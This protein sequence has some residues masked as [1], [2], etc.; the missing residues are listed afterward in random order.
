MV[1]PLTLQEGQEVLLQNIKTKLWTIKGV[2]VEVRSFG[3][4]ALVQTETG[5]FLRN[6]RFMRCLPGAREGGQE[7][8]NQEGEEDESHREEEEDDSVYLGAVFKSSMKEESSLYDLTQQRGQG[9]HTVSFR[10]SCRHK[11]FKDASGSE[12]CKGTV[13]TAGVG[14]AVCCCLQP[15]LLH[16]LCVL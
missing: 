13:V 8:D 14:S 5:I 3:K 4:S 1:S 2:I 11:D 6:W 12:E 7:Q 10:L 16:P 9:S 15:D